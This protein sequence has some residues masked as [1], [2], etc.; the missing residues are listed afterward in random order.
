[1]FSQV[2]RNFVLSLMSIHNIT[3][4]RETVRAYETRNIT[5]IRSHSATPTVVNSQSYCVVPL[6]KFQ[7]KDTDNVKVW[8]R[9]TRGTLEKTIEYCFVT[10]VGSFQLKILS[11]R[12][13][14][15]H[16]TDENKVSRKW[17]DSVH[18]MTPNLIRTTPLL[19]EFLL[20]K[21]KTKINQVRLKHHLLQDTFTNLH[22][23]NNQV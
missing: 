17:S 4:D 18:L 11:V 12:Q 20:S 19:I 6:R 9:I 15:Q 14:T 3:K 22:E 10:V 2:I 7:W 21:F 13:G 23:T 16:F 1:M 5:L 8:V